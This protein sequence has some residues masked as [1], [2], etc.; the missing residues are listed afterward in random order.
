MQSV[1]MQLPPTQLDHWLQVIKLF[2]MIEWAQPSNRTLWPHRLHTDRHFQVTANSRVWS[3]RKFKFKHPKFNHKSKDNE[4]REIWHFVCVSQSVT[5][6]PRLWFFCVL[7]KNVSVDE[8]R[9]SCRSFLSTSFSVFS[10]VLFNCFRYF[11]RRVDSWEAELVQETF[12]T[13]FLTNCYRKVNKSFSWI[14]SAP[15]PVVVGKSSF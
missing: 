11:P 9:G 8:C 3:Q 13:F 4:W 7:S 15:P 6:K 12:K 5:L 10:K 14:H 2:P 1:A